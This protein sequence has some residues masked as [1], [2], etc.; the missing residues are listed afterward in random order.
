MF[1]FTTFMCLTLFFLNPLIPIGVCVACVHEYMHVNVMWRAEDNFLES[2]LFH[3]R[4]WGSVLG[5]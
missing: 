5:P 1:N 4:I 2:I 3:S